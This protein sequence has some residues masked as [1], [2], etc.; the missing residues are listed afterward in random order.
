M[1]LIQ[2]HLIKCMLETIVLLHTS[3]VTTTANK[4]VLGTF[5]NCLPA[6]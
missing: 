6:Q 3:S 5:T 1:M 2:E 4:Q